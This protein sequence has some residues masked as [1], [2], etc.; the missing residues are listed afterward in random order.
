MVK[1]EIISILTGFGECGLDSFLGEGLIKDLPV[2]G[3]VLSVIKL[4]KGIQDKIF[5]E[6]MKVFIENVNM[7]E[8]W[9]EKFT[10]KDECEKVSKELVYIINTTDDD[11]KIKII[12]ILFNVYVQGQIDKEMFFYIS[13]IVTKSY[14]PYLEYLKE[15][16]DT[17]FN[18]D[19]KK[20]DSVKISHLLS[21][22]AFDYSGTTIS[23]LDD[24]QKIIQLPATIVRLNSFGEILK[25]MLENME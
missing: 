7:D 23:L 21:I 6:K 2:V 11:K 19:G 9:K 18:N 16:D 3:Q 17:R 13:S 4:T 10:D 12:A 15:I 25:L 24:Q 20:Y 1:E 5:A 14:Y 8:G 22:G